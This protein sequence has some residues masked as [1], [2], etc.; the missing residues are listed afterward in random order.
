MKKC[1]SLKLTSLAIS[2]A[3]IMSYGGLVLADETE[4]TESDAYSAD[5]EYNV[6][7]ETETF[8]SC[9]FGPF[10]TGAHSCDNDLVNNNVY[11]QVMGTFD[12]TG[13]EAILDKI[14]GFRWEACTNGYPDP[15]NPSENLDE[16]DYVEIDWSLYLED[17]AMIRAAESAFTR[18]H[19]TLSNRS[20]WSHYYGANS[21]CECLA[22]GYRNVLA[23]MDAWYS[24]KND[25]LNNTGAVTGHYTSMINPDYNYFA[26][27][28]FGNTQCAEFTHAS[29]AIANT[30]KDVSYFDS[31][32]LEVSPEYIT[33]STVTLTNGTTSCFVDDNPTLQVQ[34]NITYSQRTYRNSNCY[35]IPNAYSSDN[36]EIFSFEPDG[37]GT[38]HSAGTCTLS[39]S[40][41]GLTYSTVINVYEHG[42]NKIGGKWYYVNNDFSFS[43]GW[44]KVNGKWYYSNSEGVMQTGWQQIGGKWYYFTSGGEMVTG[45]KKIGSS[46]Y[47]FA[48]GGNMITGWKKLSGVWYYFKSGGA[49]ATGW[50]KIGNNWYYFESSGAML[51][52]TTRTIGGRSYNFNSSGICTNP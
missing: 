13:L 35:F 41:N 38:A 16:N 28:G 20:I 30:K 31:Q 29:Y 52:N 18:A 49:M 43:K 1:T 44:F 11:V 2:I 21:S 51:C 26:V 8:E 45:W 3:M 10:I 7:S 14:N 33:G 6:E 9:E 23:A 27:A 39:C 19:L 4:E 48:S 32:I 24:E 47:Y 12:T 34:L 40:C 36:P 42:W 46:W 25:W 22:F 5:V 50:Q 37:F 15:R 17:Y